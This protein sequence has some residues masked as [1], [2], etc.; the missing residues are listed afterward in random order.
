MTGGG[1]IEE[2]RREDGAALSLDSSESGCWPDIGERVSLPGICIYNV[3]LLIILQGFSIAAVMSVGKGVVCPTLVMA[4][5][6]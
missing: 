3:F 5:T 6:P 1:R 4:S 2:K